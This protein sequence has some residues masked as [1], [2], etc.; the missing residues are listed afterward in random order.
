MTPELTIVTAASAGYWR[1]LWQLL[2]SARRHGLDSAHR[3]VVY[4]LG[5]PAAAR[6]R[7]TSDFPWCQWRECPPLPAHAAVA[8][9][10]YAW[11]PI[12][13]HAAVGEFG[14]LVLWLD[15]ATVFRGSLAEPIAGVRRYGLYTLSGQTMLQ[16][17]CDR[18]VW[19]LADAPLE[20][21]HLPERPAGVIGID[22]AHE[23]A[24]AI[25]DRWYAMALDA[26]YWRP[27][28]KGHR[29]EQALLSI[30]IFR[31]S[32]DGRLIVN[33]G[34]IDISSPTPVRWLTTRHKVSPKFP[35]WSDALVR[36]YYASYK[37][38]DQAMIRLRRYKHTRVDGWHR[39]LQEH[40]QLFVGRT[41]A[42]NPIKILSPAD[43][44][45]ADPF[46]CR[47]DHITWVFAEEFQYRENKGRIVAIPLDDQLR[48]GP[49]RPLNLPERHLSFPFIFQHAGE[50]LLMPESSAQRTVDLYSCDCFPDRWRLRRR[51]L[52]DT[53][54]A[55]SVLM[56]HA[57]RWWLFTSLHE[58]A[59]PGR[60][61]AIYHTD[62]PLRGKWLRHPVN[63]ERRFADRPFNYGRCAGPILQMTSGELLRPIHASQR[64]YGEAVKWMRIDVLTPDAF[65][66]SEYRG[67]RPVP[68]FVPAATAHHV[69]VGDNVIAWDHRDRTGLLQAR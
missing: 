46:P 58:P 26:R 69:S 43:S 63:A 25:V 41:T 35:T 42:G 36:A 16:H 48:P 8:L 64:F 11:K 32:L 55:D 22:S 13:V 33:P 28:A 27:L 12:V 9:R 1:C 5:L 10:T 45:Y 31:S 17:Q 7:L 53:N 52:V 57:G 29:P 38:I 44:Y 19:T 3:F 60:W 59:H 50:W 68:D 54:A 67:P 6:Q 30:L 40:Y 51:V 39:R 4:D 21:L 14:G 23:V 20:I 47:N 37:T 34:E 66:E 62:D 15:S 65:V 2:R 18:T 49:A 56:P 24:R 61:L